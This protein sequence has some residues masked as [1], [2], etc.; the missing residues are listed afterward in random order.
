[1]P[2]PTL[3][4]HRTPKWTECPDLTSQFS[5]DTLRSV[6]YED[7]D[8]CSRYCTGNTVWRLRVHLENKNGEKNLSF[9]QS[10]R[11]RIL[12]F[13]KKTPVHLQKKEKEYIAEERE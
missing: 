1:M 6:R 5:N 12:V 8:I 2:K 9:M 3:T 4:G 11:T 10:I 13:E 7:F